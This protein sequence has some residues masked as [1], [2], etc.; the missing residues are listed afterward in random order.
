MTLPFRE[1]GAPYS[2]AVKVAAKYSRFNSAMLVTEIPL[3]QVASQASVNVHAPKPSLSI[4]ATIF[5][6][7]LLRSGSPC[8]NNARCATFAARNN[9]ALLFLQAA[10]QAPQPIQVAAAKD[11]SAFSFSTG[12]AFASTALPV[13]T[14]IKPPA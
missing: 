14:E 3:G 11:A 12:M 5:I 8:G 6:T 10:T 13:L 1:W 7:R 9:I 4:C 2:F